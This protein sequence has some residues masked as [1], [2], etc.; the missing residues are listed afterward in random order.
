MII[1]TKVIK[2]FNDDAKF[3]FTSGD[4]TV[5]APPRTL[6]ATDYSYIYKSLPTLQNVEKNIEVNNLKLGLIV[7]ILQYNG[8]GDSYKCRKVI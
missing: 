1:F 5:G 8:L 7:Y 3:I 6:L 2:L 4:Q